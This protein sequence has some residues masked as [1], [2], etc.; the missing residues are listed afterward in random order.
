MLSEDQGENVDTATFSKDT[1]GGNPVLQIPGSI[2]SHVRMKGQ[3][4]DTM[5]GR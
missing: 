1:D 4:Q 5:G 2:S 3:R